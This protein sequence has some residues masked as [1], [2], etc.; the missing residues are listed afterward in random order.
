MS[1]SQ[2]NKVRMKNGTVSFIS[3]NDMWKEMVILDAIK[4]ERKVK[5][6]VFKLF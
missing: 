3:E 2:K 4:S 5:I 1:Y 6:R